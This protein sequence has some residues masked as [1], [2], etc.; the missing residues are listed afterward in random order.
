MNTKSRGNELR[1]FSFSHTVL[2]TVW[3]LIQEQ[4]VNEDYCKLREFAREVMRRLPKHQHSNG[5]S[6]RLRRVMNDRP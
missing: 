1:L 5:D 6:G 2:V 4:D 3:G